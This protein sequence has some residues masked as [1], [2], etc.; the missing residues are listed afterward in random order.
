MEYDNFGKTWRIIIGFLLTF[1]LA[2]TAWA[3]PGDN[4]GYTLGFWG[5]VAG[6]RECDA[7]NQDG[8]CIAWH[9]VLKGIS[10]ARMSQCTAFGCDLRPGTRTPYRGPY[11][12]DSIA[13][14][15]AVIPHAISPVVLD[16]RAK[17]N[18]PA[19]QAVRVEAPTDTRGD[20]GPIKPLVIEMRSK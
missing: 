1:G 13:A 11:S 8:F 19:S 12:D 15:L 2:T 4:T 20:Y 17:P 18:K 16:T 14:Q 7:T 3:N 5:P 10:P 9:S 6:P